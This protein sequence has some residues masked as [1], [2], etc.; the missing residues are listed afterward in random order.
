[1]AQSLEGQVLAA[2]SRLQNPRL[3]ND[4]LSAGMVRDLAVDCDRPGRVHVPARPRGS[5]HAGARGA[6]G[7]PRARR[8]ERHQDHRG[9][10]GRARPRRPM[11]RRAGR[12]RP[13]PGVPAQQPMAQPNLG[14]V[15]AISS[16]K[17]GVGKSTVAANLA[18]ALV[19]QGIAVGLMDADV[20]GPNI[21]RMFGVFEKPPV[22]GGRIQPLEAY[23]VQAHVAGLPGGPRRAGD[24]ARPDHH[25]DRAAVPAR[26]GVGRAGLLHRGPA[27]G[28]RRRPALAGAVD[29]GGRAR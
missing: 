26:R 6:E 11:R 23:G 12:N 7:D 3:E 22:I 16:G 28:H 20:Y 15:I 14:R 8:R 25:E 5:G 13:R 29:P 24:L 19:Q 10:P 2:L 21:P 9:R 4:L 17:G 27:A 1:M 18:V